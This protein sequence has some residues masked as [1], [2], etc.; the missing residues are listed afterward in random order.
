MKRTVRR[1]LFDDG[2]SSPKPP[3]REMPK[4]DPALLH[5][6]DLKSDLHLPPP[7]LSCAKTAPVNST[8]KM[9]PPGWTMQVDNM[10]KKTTWVNPWTPLPPGWTKMVNNMN[11]KTIWVNPWTPHPPGW[12]MQVDN[13]NKVF[14]EGAHPVNG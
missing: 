11:K 1:R 5:N 7:G 9:L 8:L 3:L 6:D 12:T 10:D 2:E 13:M 4:I 14:F